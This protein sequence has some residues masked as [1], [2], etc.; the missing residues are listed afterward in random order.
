MA[1]NFGQACALETAFW[2]YVVS[3]N[4]SM[5]IGFNG[6]IESKIDTKSILP[7]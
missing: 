6:R 7:Q 2:R 3:Q 1:R 5:F 4:A